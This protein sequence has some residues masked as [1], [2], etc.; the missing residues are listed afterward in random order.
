[1]IDQ[2]RARRHRIEQALRTEHDLTNAGVIAQ[3]QENGLCAFYRLPGAGSRSTGV[4]FT[5]A[6]SL[7]VIA[8]EHRYGMTGAGQMPSHREPHDAQTDKGQ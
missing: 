6:E 5:P 2:D 8:I 3:A 1:M 4:G 7:G